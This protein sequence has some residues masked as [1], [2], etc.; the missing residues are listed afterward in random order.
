MN[1]LQDGD[2]VYLLRFVVIHVFVFSTALSPS[3]II[4]TTSV[5]HFYGN[6]ISCLREMLLVL[7][8]SLFLSIDL[9]L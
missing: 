1:A 8:T 9:R 5:S 4:I 3:F 6:Y 7:F 2:M